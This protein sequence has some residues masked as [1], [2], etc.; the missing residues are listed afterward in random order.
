MAKV[1]ISG[2]Y[3]YG[4]ADHE[5]ILMSLINVLRRQDEN[6]EIVVF[7]A[8]PTKTEDE[9]DVIAVNHDSWDAI[10]RELRS[11]DLLISGGGNLL[12][13]T[14][15]LQ[16]LKYYLK[17]IKTALRFKL[18]VFIY[19]QVIGPFTSTRAQNMVAR[20]MT[21]VRKITVADR[22]SV[23]VLHSMGIR[24]GRI[25][26]M[27]DPVLSL[28]DVEAEWK[29][30]DIAE[31][32]AKK[33]KAVKEKKAEMEDTT[34]E[35]KEP[36]NYDG[37]DVEIEIRIVDKKESPAEDSEKVS[38]NTIVIPDLEAA[39]IAETDEEAEV[40]AESPVAKK[41]EESGSKVPKAVPNRPYNLA[42]VVPSFWK[43]PVKNMRPLRFL[44][45]RKCLRPKLPL[46][47]I[48]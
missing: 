17:V 4:S 5:L 6:M 15:D 47:R 34:A 27:E 24:R 32:E 26:V 1:C 22:Q 36:V 28:T 45:S 30:T 19:N 8:D 41:T 21:K 25:H 10:K 48:I 16:E 43:K 33:A 40:E 13:E 23:D 46:W 37:K 14:D 42:Y 20:V 38:A 29:L 7:S 44:P 9:F 12:Q 2:Y 35:A 11:A 31:D 39:D 3:G 18:P